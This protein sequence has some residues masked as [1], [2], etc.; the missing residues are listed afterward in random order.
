MLAWQK[1]CYKAAERWQ[2]HLFTE[3]GIMDLTARLQKAADGM[4]GRDRE[5]RAWFRH[6]D[7]N[8]VISIGPGVSVSFTHVEGTWADEGEDEA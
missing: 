3:E 4:K 6:T 1:E 7:L 8:P 5:V 2:H